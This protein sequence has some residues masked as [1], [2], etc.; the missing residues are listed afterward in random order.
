M[1]DLATTISKA[2]TTI[3]ECLAAGVV[4]VASGLLLDIK[5]VDSHP[6]EVIDLLAAATSD[7]FQGPNVVAVENLFKKARGIE[8]NEHY[9]EEIIVNSK[10]LLHVFIRGRRNQDYV[11]C[12]ICRKTV[13]LGMAL[14][15]A[16]GS[17]PEIEMA[18]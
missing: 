7:L 1:A 10:N 2:I 16:R 17:M 14:T 13:N 4:D 3:P 6:N 8:T 11:V 9:F 18:I 12:F 15:K 5:T